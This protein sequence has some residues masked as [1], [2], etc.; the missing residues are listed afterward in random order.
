MQRR[1][2][3]AAGLAPEDIDRRLADFRSLDFSS[4][5][6]GMPRARTLSDGRIVVDPQLA[7]DPAAWDAAVD[8]S[9]AS[10]VEKENAKYY[11]TQLRDELAAQIISPLR[12][13]SP[14]FAESL[15]AGRA[16]R[17]PG[18]IVEEFKRKNSG[19]FSNLW[20]Q[21]GIAL[22]QGKAQAGKSLMGVVRMATFDTL[23][24]NLGEG[25]ADDAQWHAQRRAAL[26]GGQWAGDLTSTIVG[27]LPAV[28]VGMGTGSFPA[29][30]ATAGGQTAGDTF[31]TARQAG[32]SPLEAAG[33]ALTQGG[34]EMGI[35][36]AFG[37]TGIESVTGGASSQ[38]LVR[39]VITQGAQ[40]VPEEVAI[41]MLQAPVNEA[42]QPGSSADLPQ[43]ML[44][45]AWQ[46]FAIGGGVAALNGKPSEPQPKPAPGATAAT[47]APA[48]E[49]ALDMDALRA[50]LKAIAFEDGGDVG[51]EAPAPKEPTIWKPTEP[52]PPAPPAAVAPDEAFA[53][54]TSFPRGLLPFV[55]PEE[56]GAVM[57]AKEGQMQLVAV[58]G[59]MRRASERKAAADATAAPSPAPEAPAPPTE[60]APPAAPEAP[61]TAPA[62]TAP[63]VEVNPETLEVEVQMFGDRGKLDTP[64]KMIAIEAEKALRAREAMLRNLM[65]CIGKAYGR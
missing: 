11:R 10:D 56:A 26:G 6:S 57:A 36:A 17:T 47:A 20:D 63:A 13:A 14:E 55:T 52:E 62:E 23:P 37:K 46:S 49:P 27:T 15:E 22:S 25:F 32:W 4:T 64:K 58:Q 61:A 24:G 29:M 60:Q 9:N 51:G 30:L 12:S 28:G 21:F 41:T 53:R 50:E 65:D 16:T 1:N 59:L 33:A 35:T 7:F 39:R 43:Q 38:G 8:G 54:A 3:M 18:E 31:V 48:A 2:L 34:V 45:T 42:L 40:E 44:D 5:T 19:A